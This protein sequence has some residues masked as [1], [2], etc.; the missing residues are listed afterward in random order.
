MNIERGSARAQAG[1]AI[2]AQAALREMAGIHG[3]YHLTCMR[4]D[5]EQRKYAER[6]LTE[7]AR[8]EEMVKT[9]PTFQLLLDNAL[10]E[11]AALP[12]HEVWNTD[13]PNVVTIAGK[14]SM[15]DNYIAG[16]AFTQTGPYMG[17]ISSVSWTNL[18][19]TI[20][21]LGAYVSGTGICSI[22]TAAAHGLNPG[23]SVT[24]ASAA[25]TGTNYTAVNGTFTCLA[26]TTASVLYIFVGYGLTI[27]TLT[28]GNVTTIS[29]TRESDTMASHANWTEAG[30][31]N[32]P[33]F[34][35]RIAP[36]WSASSNGTKT[37]SAATSFTMTGSGTLEGCF[38][39]CASGAVTT[40]LNTSG[41][42]FSAGAFTG[43][44]QSVVSTDV[45]NVTYSVG[46]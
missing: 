23:D 11:F 46:V 27:T 12:R 38:L 21:S 20:T 24:I 5:D 9:R 35:A 25:G 29:G 31:T 4:V 26:S 3:T 42:L 22:N 40:I 34:S 17:L 2:A 36:A 7:I 39:V 45:V 15:L 6:L 13:A 30:T 18:A 16:S 32:A 14:N 44:A 37:V 33:T 8:L 10:D 28:G 19:T 41:T 43:G 1:A